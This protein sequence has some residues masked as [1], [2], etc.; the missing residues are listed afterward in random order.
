MGKI[1]LSSEQLN[2]LMTAQKNEITEYH[3]YTKLAHKIKNTE[4]SQILK[5]IADDELK[6]YKIWKKYTNK[7]IKPGKLKIFK[8]YLITR[9]FGL[10]FGIKLMERG[11]GTAQIN[12]Q[13]FTGTI[14][15]A[16]QIIEDEG[17]HENNLIALLKEE[18]LEYIGSIVLGLNDA[19]VELTGA[20]AGLTFAFQ[21]SRL[22]ALAGLITGIAAS[23]SMAA[24]EFLS[25]KSEGNA[26]NAFKSSVYTGIAY[27]ITVILLI[28]PYLLIQNHFIC[29]GL[30]LL[31][32]V[33][34]IFIFNFYISI[35]KDFN[36][37]KR[38]FEMFFLSLGIALLSF[39]IGF[40]LNHF[41]NIEV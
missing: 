4:N 39:G 16:K 19:L 28:L 8:Y 24:S 5:K 11:E 7:E 23:F 35:A 17:K 41:L 29:L 6:H 30:T 13:D 33:F 12:Y 20:L 9:L 40:V 10:T 26:V 36:F 34:I 32:A 31:T 1:E 3:I 22:I 25:Q 27:I 18:K 38:F 21:N 2:K 37:K 15:E 14:P